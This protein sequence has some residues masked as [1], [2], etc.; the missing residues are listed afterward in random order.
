[1]FNP[2]QSQF[3]AGYRIRK[4]LISWSL[5]GGLQQF[6]SAAGFDNDF[7]PDTVLVF[8]ETAWRLY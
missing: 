2:G 7:M 8:D 1:M 3:T 6:R 5:L 4:S